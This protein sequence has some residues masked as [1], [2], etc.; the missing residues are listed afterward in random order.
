MTKKEPKQTFDEAVAEVE[1]IIGKLQQDENTSLETMVK[2]IERATQLL[3]YCRGQLIDTEER[4]NSLFA[5]EDGRQQP[6][7]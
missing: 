1:K 7:E 2:D 3:K 4:I 5:D 6:A